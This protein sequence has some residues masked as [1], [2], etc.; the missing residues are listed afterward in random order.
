[1]RVMSNIKTTCRDSNKLQPLVKTMLNVA[2]ANA[3]KVGVTPLVVET[4]RAQE[5]QYYLYAQ[6]RT[7]LEC[8]RAGMD[9]AKANKYARKGNKVTWTLSSVH[10]SKCA[11][12]VI[13]MRNGKALWDAKAPETKK[14]IR[15]M[16]E[17][18]FEAG[19]NW[20]KSPDSPHFQVKSIKGKVVS[21]TNT[22][23]EL[24]LALQ[25]RLTDLGLYK[26]KITGVWNVNTTNGI[27]AW[28]TNNGYKATPTLN[29]KLFKKL[30]SI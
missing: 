18:G 16:T 25:T 14:L 11:V 1:M 7:A 24:T 15:C 19:A 8:V 5:R 26:S 30:M 9:V 29:R 6:G 23:L 4:Y 22:T 13:P 21:K 2:L 28:K 3:K 20:S 12:D 27:I 10:T 17:A